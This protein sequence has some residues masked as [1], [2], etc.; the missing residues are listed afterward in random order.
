MLSQGRNVEANY[1]YHVQQTADA[2]HAQ[3]VLR[4]IGSEAEQA[5]R[6]IAGLILT[7]NPVRSRE[8]VKFK[9][10]LRRIMRIGIAADI[11]RAESKQKCLVPG[12]SSRQRR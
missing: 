1:G 9:V 8:L 7:L 3:L 11:P 10:R 12:L 6:L 5:I 4:Q 2:R